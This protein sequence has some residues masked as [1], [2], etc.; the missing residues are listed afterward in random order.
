MFD[1]SQG[2]S[3]IAEIKSLK[4]AK[5]YV[6]EECIKIGSPWV[7]LRTCQSFGITLCCDNSPHKHAT[8]HYHHTHHPTIASAEPHEKWL[9]CYPDE[10]FFE[11]E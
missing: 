3:H 10:V 8:A 5:A 9:W 11:Y 4:P 6:C 1:E 2:C 7:H